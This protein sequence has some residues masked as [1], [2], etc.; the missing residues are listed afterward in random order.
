MP[1]DVMPPGQAAGVVHSCGRID[2]QKCVDAAVAAACGRHL[3]HR[4][5]RHF[6]ALVVGCVWFVS[7]LNLYYLSNR[8][9]WDVK[10]DRCFCVSWRS[11]G[12]QCL[13]LREDPLHIAKTQMARI[14]KRTTVET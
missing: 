10:L 6:A 2:Q 3:P 4:P 8:V 1:A 5:H 11:E 14:L 9:F 7:V 12:K 13:H